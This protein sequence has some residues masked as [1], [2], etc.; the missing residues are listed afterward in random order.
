MI[1]LV[2]TSF[3]HPPIFLSGMFDDD[4]SKGGECLIVDRA[5]L[6]FRATESRTSVGNG[7]KGNV[8][9]GCETEQL[10]MSS[11]GRICVG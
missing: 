2:H 1:H 5:S 11:V 3:L 9:L 10:Y 8:L 7:W 4:D 6:V